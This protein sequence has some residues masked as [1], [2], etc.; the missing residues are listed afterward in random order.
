MITFRSLIAWLLVSIFVAACASSEVIERQSYIGDE[1]LARPDRIFVYDFA[2]T[3]ADMP[4]GSALSGHYV[5]HTTPQTS[6]EV[7]TGRK[8]GAE[9][10][11]ELVTE[12]R[13]MGLPAVRAAGQAAPR[14]GDIV[15]RGYFVSIEEG[16]ADKRLLI[17]FGSG[18]TELRT[19]VEGYQMTDHGLRPLGMR[20][21]EAG[22]GEMP[23]LLVPVAVVAA[24]GNP[25]GLIVGG[26]AKLSGEMGSETIEGAAKRT[27]KEISK[28]LESVFEREGWIQVAATNPDS[29]PPA[30]SPPAANQPAASPAA[31]DPGV[32]TPEPTQSIAQSAGQ[33]AAASVA[34]RETFALQLASFKKAETAQQ[35][36][37]LIQSKFPRLLDDTPVTVQPASVEGVGQVYRLKAG[38]YPTHATAADVCAQLRSA[39]QDCLVVKR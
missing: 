9:V 25:V 29:V 10:A 23:G 22:G 32:Q 33:T 4:A 2:A 14:V 8:L 17:G 34:S 18:A 31:S 3:P 13:A 28:E 19:V 5:A 15:I 16:A 37:A 39:Q 27:A 24:T 11:K 30:S 12:M 26:A 6:E 20:E 7:E 1:K 21:T 36:W 35:E 38:V